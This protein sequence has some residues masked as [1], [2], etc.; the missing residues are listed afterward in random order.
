MFG[1][2]E[3][4]GWGQIEECAFRVT[5]PLPPLGAPLPPLGAPLPPLGAPLGPPLRP[6]AQNG[7]NL[8]GK[9]CLALP[10]LSDGE[11]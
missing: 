3:S 6:P 4:F 8:S 2:A 7:C 10:S 11:K 9:A 5:P 1:F